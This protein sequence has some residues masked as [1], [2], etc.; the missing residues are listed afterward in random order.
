M[1]TY[2]QAS[3]GV[4]V[5][6]KV[7]ILQD[8]GAVEAGTA[9]MGQSDRDICTELN[10]SH[11]IPLSYLQLVRLIHSHLEEKTDRES[12]KH[13]LCCKVLQMAHYTPDDEDR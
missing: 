1:R 5:L 13:L 4:P 10:N 12:D 3:N 7:F 8:S 11:H 6:I 2:N 9:G